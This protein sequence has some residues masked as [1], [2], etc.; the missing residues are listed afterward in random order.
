LATDSL[1]V[2]LRTHSS[3]NYTDLEQTFGDTLL[4]GFA[5]ICCSRVNLADAALGQP[6]AE[7]GA[8]V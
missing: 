8:E 7:N 2:R 4:C 3:T 6:G 1:R 5:L